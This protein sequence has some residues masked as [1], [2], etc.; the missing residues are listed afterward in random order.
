MANRTEEVGAE[1]KDSA[2][3]GQS[4]L[5]LGGEK[6][7]TTETEQKKFDPWMEPYHLE[8]GLR[9]VAPYHFTYKTYCK[10]RWR[11]RGILD[12]FGTEFR[13]R[14]KEYYK[15]AIEDGNLQI[16]GKAVA[17]DTPVKNG[18]CVSHTLHRHEP[19][20]TSLPIGIIHE[21]DN[22]IVIDKPAGVPVH[23]AGRYNHNSII[24]IMRAERGN[25]WNP[26]PCNRLDRLTSG[27]MFIGKKPKAAE[28]IS[29][30]LRARTVQKE[31]I[32]RVK[33]KFPDGIVLCDQPMLKISPVLGL[34]R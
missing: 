12:I 23:P 20:V 9:R 26:L 11:G 32:A 8:N 1:E 24:E 16:N 7:V 4:L 25:G 34:N 21:D 17:I 19:P 14:P 2:Q 22:M 13:D 30:Q 31:Y 15:K 28:A 10:E 27:V 5:S 6:E 3:A 33:G 18:D 29:E